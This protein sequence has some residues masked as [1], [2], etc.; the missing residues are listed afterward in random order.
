MTSALEIADS[1]VLWSVPAE[2]RGAAL[3]S[4]PL[5]VLMHGRGSDE[6]DLFALTPVLP[7]EAVVASLR[8]PLPLGAAYS[9]FP[10]AQPGL[11]SPHAAADATMA[12]L[13]WL[14]RVGH[15]GPTWLLGFSQG[16]AMVTQLL[17]FDAQRFDKF[18]NLS[19]FSIHG[20][21]PNDGSLETLRPPLFW[22]RDPADPV[23]PR[24]AVERTAS[25]LPGHT[26]LTKRE[27]PGVGHSISR[28]ELDE[29]NAFLAD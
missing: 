18:V 7:P 16:G 23:I 21:L 5:L 8:A 28:E 27:Y 15:S 3:A 29:V 14:D 11:P 26:T 20:E 22:G 9:W 10:V 17:R 25:W 13:D 6:N 19:G 24:D 4:R 12:V 2:H 1:A